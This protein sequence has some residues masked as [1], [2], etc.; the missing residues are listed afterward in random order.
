MTTFD[1]DRQ[2]TMP[3]LP[4]DSAPSRAHRANPQEATRELVANMGYEV[5]PFKGTEDSVVKYVPTSVPL[6]VTTTE[7]KGIAATLELSERLRGHGYDVAP[8]LAARQVADE[9]ELAAIVERMRTA[10]ITRAFVVGGDAPTPAGKYTDALGLLQDLETM[11]HDF[12]DVGIGGYPEGHGSIAEDL[13]DTALQAKAAHATRVVTQICFDADTTGT[14]GEGLLR[15][16]GVDLPI[17]VGMPG[18]VN[19]QKLIRISAGIGLGQSARFLQKQQ[20]L[21]RFFLPGAYNPTRLVRALGQSAST[22]QARLHGLHI[23]TFNELEGTEKW[24]LKLRK[25]LDI[26]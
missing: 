3:M 19:R 4:E 24:R 7:A 14:W 17:Y 10:G 23:F 13:I 25:Q 18:P 5:M 20:G 15:D 12:L 26:D 9:T 1:Q 22:H 2:V 16:R 6:T 8:H 21:W 11:G